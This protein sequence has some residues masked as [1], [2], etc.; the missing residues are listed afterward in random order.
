MC[1]LEKVIKFRFCL[2]VFLLLGG[3]V[4][5]LFSSKVVSAIEFTQSQALPS[6]DPN[7]RVEL[8]DP[9]SD[10][11]ELFGDIPMRVHVNNN[12]GRELKD[13]KI[14]YVIKKDV[15]STGDVTGVEFDEYLSF[16][17]KP[18]TYNFDFEV[19]NNYLAPTFTRN[20]LPQL[21]EDFNTILNYRIK[22]KF[23]NVAS[24]G[25]VSPSWLIDG[26][27]EIQVRFLAGDVVLA[28]QVLQLKKKNV[29]PDYR[30]MVTEF[31]SDF[32]VTRKDPITITDD[33]SRYAWVQV[34]PVTEGLKPIPQYPARFTF[35]L[36]EG[37]SFVKAEWDKLY[38]NVPVEV[39]GQDVSMEL[40][41]YLVGNGWVY[42]S[43]WFHKLSVF[44][45]KLPIKFE[46]DVRSSYQFT[47]DSEDIPN[48]RPYILDDKLIKQVDSLDLVKNTDY[49]ALRLNNGDYTTIRTY[50]SNKGFDIQGARFSRLQRGLA[51]KQ[52]TL[53]EVTSTTK[54]YGVRA[55]GS[56]VEIQPVLRDLKNVPYYEKSYYGVKYVYKDLDAY[57][58]IE[59]DYGH[60]KGNSEINWTYE[61][62]DKDNLESYFPI[63]YKVD[64]REK[65]VKVKVYYT[66]PRFGGDLTQ[67]NNKFV[68]QNRGDLYYLSTIDSNLSKTPYIGH[69]Q[70]YVMYKYEKGMTL[71]H[72]VY[73]ELVK[74]EVIG[75]Y[76]YDLT[77]IKKDDTST[78]EGQYADFSPVFQDGNHRVTGKIFFNHDDFVPDSVADS[79]VRQPYDETKSLKD[80]YDSTKNKEY[81]M[82]FTYQSPRSLQVAALI[83]GTTGINVVNTDE[84]YTFEHYLMNKSTQSYSGVEGE[85][86]L[87][88]GVVLTELV[89][90]DSRYK[91]LYKVGDSWVENPTNLEG[92][93]GYKVVPKVEGTSLGLQDIVKTTAKVKVK[94]VTYDAKLVIDSK[95]TVNGASTKAQ[96]VVLNIKDVKLADGTLEVQYVNVNGDFLKEDILQGR[97]GT[98]YEVNVTDFEKDGKN[99]GF[100]H[101]DG[102]LTGSYEGTKTKVV[103]VYMKEKPKVYE[104]PLTGKL[105]FIWVL[106]SLL[107]ILVITGKHKKIKV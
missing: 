74:R 96:D 71:Q 31:K 39:L 70:G 34:V 104:L 45:L 18:N 78:I 101:A 5:S 37:V 99:Y 80:N 57:E 19:Y 25:K 17:N 81:V 26:D 1:L 66:E 91:V 65:T 38:P 93:T 61:I 92:V 50:L 98:N 68:N 55:D 46:G 47:V 36:P 12:T 54:V 15:S 64:G 41:P 16:K 88:N 23:S 42:S 21:T 95:M 8:V 30:L 58:E 73:E 49:T 83:N 24:F 20:V 6:S 51:L 2:L 102:D 75:D 100:D 29:K 77:R 105:D 106:V 27:T 94:D 3:G 43:A 4:Y 62:T 85:I 103:K 32:G 14:Q 84:V 52:F 72:T 63:T 56:K 9:P 97:H 40:P 22:D 28:E 90:T 76:V 35:H 87:P 89:T 60:N 107:G 7:Y 48:I 69:Y 67:R 10:G 86:N 44:Y 82:D 53:S 79:T 11:Y 59:V 13:F 33:N